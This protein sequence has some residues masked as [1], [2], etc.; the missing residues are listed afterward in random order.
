M[1][2]SKVYF[3]LFSHY[4]SSLLYMWTS[5]TEGDKNGKLTSLDHW[6]ETE[7]VQN[8]TQKLE[9]V[10]TIWRD[11]Y[12]GQKLDHWIKTYNN[13]ISRK[14]APFGDTYN[15]MEVWT[16]EPWE[17][18]LHEFLC[19]FWSFYHANGIIVYYGLVSYGLFHFAS[20][21]IK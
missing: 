12:T 10:E 9:A 8:E 14:D 2:V 19:S 17:N 11:F 16:Y 21:S 20:F 7:A 15:C 3:H 1:Y 4:C 18:S 13:D 5:A 6:P